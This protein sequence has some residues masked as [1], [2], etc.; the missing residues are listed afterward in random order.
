MLIMHKKL[1]YTVYWTWEYGS[2]IVLKPRK[3]ATV[4]AKIHAVIIP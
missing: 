2:K 3:L 4:V 1:S